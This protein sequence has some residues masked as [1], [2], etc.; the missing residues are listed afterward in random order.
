MGVDGWE[1]VLG[2]LE[3][4]LGGVGVGGGDSAPAMNRKYFFFVSYS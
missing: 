2:Y 4:V 3:Y 1:S